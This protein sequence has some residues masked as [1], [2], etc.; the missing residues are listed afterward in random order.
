MGPEM[1]INKGELCVVDENSIDSEFLEENLPGMKIVT[2]LSLL[3]SPIT[4][5]SVESIFNKKN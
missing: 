3:V 5:N 4:M 1:N 2:V